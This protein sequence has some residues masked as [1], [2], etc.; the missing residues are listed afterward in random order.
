MK[1]NLHLTNSIKSFALVFNISYKFN[2][3][4]I[5]CVLLVGFGGKERSRII[6]MVMFIISVDLPIVYDQSNQAADTQSAGKIVERDEYKMRKKP[7]GRA[8]FIGQS[9]VGSSM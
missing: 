1:L 5:Y 9:K 7:K 4:L 8:K 3:V 2:L 6:L